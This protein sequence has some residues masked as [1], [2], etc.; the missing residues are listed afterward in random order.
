VDLP[1]TFHRAID[2]CPAL[3][4]AWRVLAEL[5]C[6]QVLTA[7]SPQGLKEGLSAVVRRAQDAPEIR[8]KIMAGG[9][10]L[11][12]HV[13]PLARAGVRSF[14]IGSSARPGGNFSAHVAPERVQAWRAL[15]DASVTDAGRAA[16]ERATG[17]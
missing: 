3:D 5:G 6:D 7:G 9:G 17:R 16:H 2:A 14:H 10:L 1:W 15:I 12:T 11:A 13:P 8:T 4:D